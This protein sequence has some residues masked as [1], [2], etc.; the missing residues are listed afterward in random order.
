MS[1]AATLPAQAATTGAVVPSS[2]AAEANAADWLRT[3]TPIKHL[4][5]IYDENVSFD[6][7]FGTYPSAT[8]PAGEPRF[9]PL[10]GTTTPDNLVTANVLTN[11]PNASNTANGAGA[12]NPYRLD[13]TQ[14]ATADQNHGYTAEQEAYDKGK[15]DAFPAHTGSGTSGGAGTFGT[16][17]QV[18]GYYDGN[19]V[20]ALWNYAQYFAMN[21]N[22]FGNTYGPS[23]PGAL[24]VVSG[25]TDGMDLVKS[26]AS[27][28][29]VTNTVKG[30]PDYTMISDVDPAYDVCSSTTN[31][32]L[33]TG[34]NIGDLLNAAKITWGGFMGGF[35]LG[36]TNPN[37]T[38]GCGRTSMNEVVG[39]AESDYIPHHNWFQYFASTAN[40]NHLRPKSVTSIGYSFDKN[41]APDPANHEYDLRDF[42]RAIAAGN[43]PAVSYI[44][45]VG[46]QDGHAGYS[47]PLDEQTGLVK[48]INL[49]Q[50]QPDWKNTAII[51]NWD[52]S[53]GWYDH[54]FTKPTSSSYDATADQLNGPGVCGTGPQPRG[55]GGV[56][57][58]GRCGPGPR[59]PF[60]VI[61]PWARPNYIDHTRITQ[62]SVVSFIEDNWLGGERL[63]GGAFD[64][65]D[66][67][68]MSMF[69]FHG[70]AHTQFLILNPSTGAVE[71]YNGSSN[72]QH[73]NKH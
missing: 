2:L 36:I 64:A 57:I 41:G 10:P 70:G 12:A 54:Q 15:A 42:E 48:L 6:H 47:D 58:N 68:I 31:Q 26:T 66:Q 32:V 65:Q 13:R 28:Y 52:D 38:T 16:T 7:Y 55:L 39:A 56:S 73:P 69:D 40:P 46:Y 3:A 22:S 61:S 45:L 62:A 43:F 33:M 18:M 1:A 37:G 67:S 14:A 29:Y 24:E 53:D 49:V 34:K 8:N 44:K 27:S 19:T 4:V 35:N 50:N 21:D 60:L 30:Q 63:G 72:D 71:L 17:G 11:N 51:I 23:T 25:N 5:V 59:L 20:T 9:K